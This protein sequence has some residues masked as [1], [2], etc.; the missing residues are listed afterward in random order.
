MTLPTS[1]SVSPDSSVVPATIAV[2]NQTG[3][4]SWLSDISLISVAFIWGINIPFMKNGLD[5]MDWFAF[6]AI[7]LVFSALVLA[8]L[9][10]NEYRRGH[11]PAATLR[12]RNV[13]V[14][15]VVVSGV[16]QFLFLLGISRTTS[17]NTALIISTIPMWTALAARVFLLERLKLLA[18]FG[19]VVAFAGTLIVA[20][21]KP[22]LELGR[23]TLIG[24]LCIV[25][26]ALGWAAGTVISRP[27]LK[28]ISPM[29]LSAWSAVIA[30]P[31]HVAI[32]APALGESVKQLANPAVL[33]ILLYS[34]VFSTGLALPMWSFGVRHAGA[35]RASAFQNLVPVI[36]IASA[37]LVRGEAAGWIQVV[38]GG[39]IIGG[40]VIMRTAK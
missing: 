17:A 31:F 35:A 38:G 11:R 39:L 30:L 24:N 14:Y 21:Q 37:W 13:L 25:G 1:S 33:A 8:G 22:D 16:Y 18:W 6:N 29:Q 19:L 4:R 27:L 28:S 15:A 40:L 23:Q 7:R 10:S 32:A 5:Q 20:L 12:K 2:E 9:A 34:G 26:A 3:W 36:A